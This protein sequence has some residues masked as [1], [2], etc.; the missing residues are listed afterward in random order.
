MAPI[1]LGSVH[2]PF[3]TFRLKMC[4][5]FRRFHSWTR[6][7]VSPRSD[8]LSLQSNMACNEYTTAPL[9]VFDPDANRLGFTVSTLRWVSSSFSQWSLDSFP[10]R[11]WHCIFDKTRIIVDDHL[12][13]NRD[14]EI[15]LSYGEPSAL[16]LIKLF[17]N[18]PK[19]VFD[20]VSRN[21]RPNSHNDVIPWRVQQ[22][23]NAIDLLSCWWQEN[24]NFWLLF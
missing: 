24:S 17:S 14:M 18:P 19:K 7:V 23:R 10:S 22:T 9:H 4:T 8:A 5:M 12:N 21:I 15:V 13:M 11:W 16:N 3:Q 6:C 2:F 20:S 1:V